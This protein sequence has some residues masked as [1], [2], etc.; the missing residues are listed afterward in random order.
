MSRRRAAGQ[1]AA[2]PPL[3]GRRQPA[4]IIA[5][6]TGGASDADSAWRGAGRDLCAGAAWAQPQSPGLDALAVKQRGHPGL[7]R[8]YRRRR[9]RHAGQPGRVS[10]PRQRSLPRLAAAMFGDPTGPL[11]RRRPAR[12]GCRAAIRPDRRADPHHDLVAGARHRQRA[13]LHRGDL[14]RRP[15]LPGAQA[16]RR[17]SGPRSWTAPRSASRR[18]HQRAE[19]GGLGRAPTRSLPPR[20]LRAERRGT[21][22]LR[23]G[24]C[25]AYTTDA[26]QLAGAAAPSLPQPGG[27]RRPARHHLQGAAGPRCARATTSGSTSCAGRSSR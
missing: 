4:S 20:G 17:D 2:S 11:P 26:C 18:Q 21:A 7:R 3:P 10:R 6:W 9:L 12:R 16:L 24:R 14:L 8:L 1:A 19:P 22:R 13:E 23:A 5:A 27:P 15:G 25:D